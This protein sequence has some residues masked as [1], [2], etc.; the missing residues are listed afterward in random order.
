MVAAFCESYRTRIL[1]APFSGPGRKT[2]SR[3]LVDDSW[4]ISV[5]VLDLAAGVTFF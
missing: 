1:R 3:S 4:R 5:G 2:N